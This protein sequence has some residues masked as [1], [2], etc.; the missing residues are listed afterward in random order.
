VRG[1]PSDEGVLGCPLARFLGVLTADGM[2]YT[3]GVE[4]DYS[5]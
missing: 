3:E 5:E 1:G 2:I 4:V